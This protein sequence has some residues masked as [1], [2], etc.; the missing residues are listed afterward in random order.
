MISRLV[1]NNEKIENLGK[2]T[3]IET[4]RPPQY[5]PNIYCHPPTKE[6]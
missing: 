4:I 6:H 5:H 3:R 2:G 1:N